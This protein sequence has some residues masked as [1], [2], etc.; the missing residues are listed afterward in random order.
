MFVPDARL[1]E[2][3]FDNAPILPGVAQIALAAA[4]CA[5]LGWHTGPLRGVRDVK[6]TRPVGLG[7]AVDIRLSPGRE[8]GAI[9]F[10]IRSADQVAA[11]GVLM[12]GA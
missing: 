3:H 12:F 2:G 5:E 11:T 7:D 4:A 1:F 10:E 8:A 6:F 9:T